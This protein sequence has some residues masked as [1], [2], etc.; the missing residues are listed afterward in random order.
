VTVQE[1]SGDLHLP[2]LLNKCSEGNLFAGLNIN[3]ALDFT[4]FNIYIDW[5]CKS[6]M[7]VF[8][9]L[10]TLYIITHVSEVFTSPT[11]RLR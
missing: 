5:T 8:W 2:E 10:G 1:I 7:I 4:G 9:D 11:T 6:K 3:F